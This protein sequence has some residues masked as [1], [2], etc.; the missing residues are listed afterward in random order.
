M[1]IIAITATKISG[2]K[3]PITKFGTEIYCDG[4]RVDHN[5]TNGGSHINDI[6]INVVCGDVKK[7]TIDST[8]ED[9]TD[10]D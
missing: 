10:G 5:I 2:G 9:P 1:Y 6:Y 4:F 7:Y 3:E 8:A